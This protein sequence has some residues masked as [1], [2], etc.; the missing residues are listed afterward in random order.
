M[1]RFNRVAHKR[2][3]DTSGAAL[4]GVWFFKG[5]G[6]WSFFISPSHTI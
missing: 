1:M 2:A 6:F 3:P 4:F 5:C